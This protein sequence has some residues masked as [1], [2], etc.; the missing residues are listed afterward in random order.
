MTMPKPP[1]TPMPGR[2][3]MQMFTP[4]L[5]T[6]LNPEIFEQQ[7]KTQGVR[8]IHS[9]PVPCPFVHDVYAP[10]H[11]PGCNLCYNGFIYYD[12]REFIG[13]FAGNDLNR[14]FGMNGTFDVDQATIIIPVHD[15]KDQIMD[16]QY[17][18]QILIPDFTVRYYQRIEHSQSGIDRAQFPVFS[19]DFAIDCNGQVYQ[20]GI[21]LIVE[22]GRIRWISNNRPG[23]DPVRGKGVIY[24]VNYYTRPVFTI[25]G[26]PH[27]LRMVQTKA[28]GP[29]VQARF[30]QFAVVRKDFIPF[31]VTDKKG[32]PDRPEPRDGSFV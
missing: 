4:L 6:T 23:Y 15:L 2:S 16:V 31:D 5:E 8:M 24:S 28:D 29:N 3:K 30:P 12:E 1:G 21:D 32:P 7:I 26:L 20:P 17:F 25:V 10:D 19:I 22:N 14:S 11:N 27:Q 13:L 18:D 9:R